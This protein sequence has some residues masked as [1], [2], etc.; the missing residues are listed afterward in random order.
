MLRWPTALTPWCTGCRF[1]RRT[2]TPTAVLLRPHSCN[3]PSDTIAHSLA[4]SSA[5][6]RSARQV[7]GYA[8]GGLSDLVRDM[9]PASRGRPQRIY[10]RVCRFSNAPASKLRDALLGR[11]GLGIE[12]AWDASRAVGE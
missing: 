1:P 3:S 5:T 8:S 7:T 12:A 10:T 4:A 6:A 9:A 2:R 11:R